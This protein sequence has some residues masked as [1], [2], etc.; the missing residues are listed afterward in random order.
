MTF[1]CGYFP[2]NEMLR[3]I[4]LNS[5]RSSIIEEHLRNCPACMK[6][7]IE[8]NRINARLEVFKPGTLP[9]WHDLTVTISEGSVEGAWSSRTA[10]NL[11]PLA[12]SR[13]PS[14]PGC[15]AVFPEGV[16]VQADGGVCRITLKRAGNEKQVSEIRRKGSSLPLFS[17]KSGREEVVFRGIG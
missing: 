14:S 5:G 8:L 3:Y 16:S 17:E 11:V 13:G 1:G 15:M 2:E 10:V 6:E 12:Y 9:S 7:I 4:D